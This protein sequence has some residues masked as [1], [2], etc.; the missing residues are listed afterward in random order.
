MLTGKKIQLHTSALC[1]IAHRTARENGLEGVR[2]CIA[3]EL[4]ES[5][6]YNLPLGSKVSAEGPIKGSN[7]QTGI[8]EIAA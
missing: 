4:L 3:F 7:G 6:I 5:N 2:R 8:S 1:S